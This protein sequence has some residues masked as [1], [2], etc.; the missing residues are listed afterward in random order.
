MTDHQLVDQF[1]RPLRSATPAPRAGYDAAKTTRDN[2]KLWKD[3]DS[4]AAVS[5]LT[6]GVRRTLRNRA[7]YECQNNTYAAGLV[8]TLVGDTVGRG[9]RLQMQTDDAALNA[10]VEDL[11]RTWSAA[12]NLPLN[13]RVLAGVR[14]VAG[15]CFAVFRDSKRLGKAGYPITLDLRLIEPDQVTH[16]F[17]GF[18]WQRH[19]DD[20]VVC[21]DDDEVTAYKIL[22]FHPG[23][24]RA[25]NVVLTPDTVPAENVLHWFQ[26]ERPGQLRG[27]TPLAPAL[28]IFGQL[29]RFT[30]AVLTGAEFAA[31]IAGVIESQLSADQTDPAVTAEE[32]FDVIDVVKGMLLT[33][34]S[35]TTAKGFEPK[36]PT[37]TYEMF[38]NAKLREC[39]RMLNVPFGKMAG[40]HSRYNYSSG[41]LDTEAYWSDRD[42]ERQE[43][44]AKVTDPLFWKW[45]D[46]ARFVLPAL[47]AF[48]GQFWQLKHCWH[49]D[50]RPSSD[51]VKD[52]TG[53][54]L[55]LT[56]G[57]DT[58]AAIAARDGTTEDALLD[59]RAETKRK[60]E[61][62][63]LPLP[64]W[65]TGATATAK[66]AAE[67]TGGPQD[68]EA[69]AYAP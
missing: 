56:S 6:P 61:D 40:D 3:T 14:Y 49:Y 34:P 41:K 8:R 43:F 7:R 65:L 31:S 45:C 26:P 36:H 62:R 10:G 47:A 59:A 21:D 51:P 5:Q 18:P 25:F 55:N 4:L 39:G 17:T 27:A 69:P 57:S 33:L 15:E 30:E 53:D 29:R 1:G 54:D 50:A 20:G 46:F 12:V 19:G 37:T 66:L 44:E 22:K 67:P 52:A 28:P 24:N 13:L 35:G 60:F 42:V 16:G 11:W 23:D 2:R 63:G 68:Q 64:A 58:L 32:Y 38:L 9:P 48:K